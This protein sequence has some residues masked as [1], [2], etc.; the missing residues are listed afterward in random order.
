MGAGTVTGGGPNGLYYVNIEYD[1]QSAIRAIS[2]IEFEIERIL[3]E[4]EELEAVKDQCEAD[5]AGL[6]AEMSEKQNAFIAA[7]AEISG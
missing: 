7:V 2:E 4:I 1:T 5:I 6:E 3:T